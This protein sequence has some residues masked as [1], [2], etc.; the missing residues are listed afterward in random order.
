M[1]GLDFFYGG[2]TLLSHYCIHS[3]PQS[4]D[5]S[6]FSE[7]S[8]DPKAMLLQLVFGLPSP[9]AIKKL[10]ASVSTDSAPDGS[11]LILTRSDVEWDGEVESQDL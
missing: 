7:K 6:R 2:I 5:E 3:T 9:I 4:G 8:Y 11:Y 1:R 10:L